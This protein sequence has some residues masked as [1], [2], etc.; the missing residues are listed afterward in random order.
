MTSST[1]QQNSAAIVPITLRVNGRT[2]LTLW[3]PPWEDDEGEEW[4]GFLGDGSKILLFPS[5]EELAAFVASGEENDLSD[6][7]AWGQVLKA[8][9]DQL[10][11]GA[12]SHYDLDE[13]YEWASGEPDPVHVSALADVVDMVAKI[14]DCCDDGA[15]RRLVEGTPAYAELVDEENSYQGRDG[16]KRWNEL[17]DVIA[18]SWERAIRRV[19][20]WLSWRGDFSASDFDGEQSAWA[21]IGAQP[22]ELRF[23]DAIYYTVRGE[24]PVNTDDG[25]DDVEIAF[26]GVDQSVAVFTDVADLA[27]YCRTADGHRLAKL[28]WW[29]EVAD[30]DQDTD[31]VPADDAR[32]DLRK[33]STEGADLLLDIAD[34]CGI[35]AD[36][37]ALSENNINRD[38]WAS[39]IA[40]V[41][42]VLQP[43]D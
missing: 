21:R 36:V 31:F 40:N 18:D 30:F 23:N 11:P 17:G 19:E 1:G 12:E 39:A 10:R 8:T 37:D 6:H 4:Q 13:V 14:A 27:R 9:P 35:E 25:E 28:Q 16:R 29:S 24:I 5:V 2:G 33:P 20:D 42:S 34:F 7:P 3:A 15:L 22:I 38:D 26:L 41:R 43:Q 32:Y